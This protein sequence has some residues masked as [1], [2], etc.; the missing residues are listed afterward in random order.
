MSRGV[1]ESERETISL[2]DFLKKYAADSIRMIMEVPL[3]TP[4]TYPRMFRLVRDRSDNPLARLGHVAD[5]VEWAPGGAVTLRW[6]GPHTSV[7]TFD[8]MAALKAV[9]GYRNPLTYKYDTRV[10]YKEAAPPM[11][12]R[13]IEAV[14]E[15]YY[16]LGDY[17]DKTQKQ[18]HVARGDL[19]KAFGAVQDLMVEGST[20][21]IPLFTETNTASP[22]A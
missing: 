13:L 22:A 12:R 1:R 19:Q 5:G 15:L 11:N 17:I 3:M 7:A 16:V 4:P 20:V 14:D 9:H 21:D 6:R 10:E 8:R 2:D 18:A